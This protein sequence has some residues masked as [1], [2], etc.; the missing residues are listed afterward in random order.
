MNQSISMGSAPV[1][2]ICSICHAVVTCQADACTHLHPRTMK[3]A[4]TQATAELMALSQEE[5]D[6]RLEEA[7]KSDLAQLFN[8]I[9]PDFTYLRI[10]GGPVRTVNTEIMA[11]QVMET[12]NEIADAVVPCVL[13]PPTK[14]NP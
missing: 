2:D 7:S 9:H 3:E 6:K 11:L 8:D 4:I 1:P 5:F 14:R 12:I 10:G 13:R